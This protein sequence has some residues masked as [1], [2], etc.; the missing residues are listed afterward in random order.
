[1][2]A[3]LGP[4]LRLAA[5]LSAASPV[6]RGDVTA[7]IF[8]SNIYE[9]QPRRA[10][11]YYDLVYLSQVGQPLVD[12]NEVSEIIPGVAASW[13]ISPDRKTY[14]FHIREG[15]SFHD[16]TPLELEDVVYSLNQTVYSSDS[17]AYYYL[18]VLQGYEEGRGT[19]SCAGIRALPGR[20][21]ELRL[22]RPYTPLLRSLTSGA[23]VIGKR[24]RGGKEE[25]FIGT[26]PYRL[27]RKGDEAVLEA[28][29]QYRG[30]YPPKIK[31]IRLV[32]DSEAM[33]GKKRLSPAA[34]PDFTVLY[35][36]DE[37][38]RLDPREFN[39][40]RRP[41]MI[42]SG[43]YLNQN[44]P[45]LRLK[46]DRIGLI[47]ALAHVTA[48]MPPGAPGAALEDVYPAGMLGH[49]AKRESFRALLGVSG[50]AAPSLGMKELTVGVFTPVQGGNEEFARRFLKETGVRVTFLQLTHQNML[51]ELSQ[52]KADVFFLRWKSVFLD[53]ETSLTPFQIV[54]T[55]ELSPRSK[56]FA[57]L[58]REATAGVLN[59]E[60]ADAYGKIADLIF[61]DALYFPVYQRDELQAVRKNITF[62]GSIYRYSPMFSEL[63]LKHGD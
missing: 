23:M 40:I 46:Q 44:S 1:M 19:K 61:Q 27:V 22:S 8:P 13:D 34:M 55:F 26:G 18:N 51:E 45:N 60:R 32:A 7:G 56:R 11:S 49:K 25:G 16:G 9:V 35:H 31:R 50:A 28:F 37:M 42:T 36:E 2:I 33:T 30:P 63:Q 39:I 59:A 48:T 21:I 41:G 3:G 57:T 47:R 5:V 20:I 6:P 54:K 10:T 53:P 38:G 15:L 29:A 52:L 58:R 17:A 62:S 43:F 14:R 24:P 12:Q 4:A